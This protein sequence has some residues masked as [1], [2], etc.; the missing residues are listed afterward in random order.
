MTTLA[1]AGTLALALLALGVGT[2]LALAAP[3]GWSTKA[4]RVTAL[5]AALAAGTP[6][7][8][9]SLGGLLTLAVPSVRVAGT[10]VG[11]WREGRRGSAAAGAAL[12]VILLGSL[13]AAAVGPDAPPTP[14]RR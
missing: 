12:L 9:L 3:A 11:L 14:E 4:V 2:A 6:A 8:W 7:A 1:V 10:L 13:G 5:P